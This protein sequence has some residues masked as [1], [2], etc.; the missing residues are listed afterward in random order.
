MHF[1]GHSLPLLFRTYILESRW[2]RPKKNSELV[3]TARALSH[4][5]LFLCVLYLKQV[6]RTFVS[7]LRFVSSLMNISLGPMH[8]PLY[9]FRSPLENLYMFRTYWR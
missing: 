5:F 2:E 3:A 9:G 4:E 1:R 8:T 6:F 7:N